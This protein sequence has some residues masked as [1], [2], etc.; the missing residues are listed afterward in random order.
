MCY[1]ILDLDNFKSINDTHGHLTG[2]KV[3]KSLASMLRR[4]FRR[5]D[6][7]GRYGG[8]EFVVI[9]QDTKIDAAVVVMNRVREEFSRFV[10]FSDD[11][12]SEFSTTFS[13]G[14]SSFPQ[15]STAEEIQAQADRALYSAKNAGR[16]K[17][18]VF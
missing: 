12:G 17:V 10:H 6:V 16:N 2:D 14:M 15:F 7:V 5:S 8:E 13:A 1:V 18:S 4:S 3:I 9:M 11:D